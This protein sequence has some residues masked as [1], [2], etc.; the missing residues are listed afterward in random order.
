MERARQ[1][2]G[3]SKR[4][5][6]EKTLI[7][8]AAVIGITVSGF[9]VFTLAMGTSSPL[10]VVTSN[11]MYPSLE[12]GH[13][14]V[15]QSYQPE[16]IQ[17]GN[18]I[19]Y[20]ADWHPDAPIVHRVVEIVEVGDEYHYYTKGD[21][22]ADR[23]PYYRTY[24]DI[25]GVVVLAIPYVGYITLILHE[26]AGFITVMVIFLALLILPE[27]LVKGDEEEEAQSESAGA[28]ENASSDA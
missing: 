11:S 9:G 19:V 1:L 27:F 7:V 3:W 12:R 16:D 23:D 24:D 15:L 26:P 2:L 8:V 10:V 17:V 22:N 18:I 5:D 13:L 4:S 14:L 21:A 6:L 28:A 25:V 20:N